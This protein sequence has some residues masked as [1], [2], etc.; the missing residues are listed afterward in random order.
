VKWVW[1]W[2]GRS[3]GYLDGADLWTYQ[4]KH[5]GRC[6]DSDIYSPTGRYLGEIMDNGR[7][8]TN[9]AKAADRGPTF[10]RLP[11]REEVKALLDAQ[12]QPMYRGFQD[13]PA[14]DKL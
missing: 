3:F 2:S 6:L 5:V 12:G 11:S 8:A 14:P 9:K 7:L 10:A 4:G 13:F 1:T